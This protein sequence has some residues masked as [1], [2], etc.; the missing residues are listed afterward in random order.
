[1]LLGRSI[2]YIDVWYDSIDIF[3][4]LIAKTIVDQKSY[5]EI[6]EIVVPLIVP[7]PYL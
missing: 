5:I 3:S 4:L 2:I 1:M 6:I 7:K